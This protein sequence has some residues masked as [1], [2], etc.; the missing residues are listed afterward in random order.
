MLKNGAKKYKPR[1]GRKDEGFSK[2]LGM[3]EMAKEVDD[4]LKL[5]DLLQNVLKTLNGSINPMH[6]RQ[7]DQ[8]QN[9]L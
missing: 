6:P 1:R 7:A 5:K 3:R 9:D 8:K 4:K 2:G